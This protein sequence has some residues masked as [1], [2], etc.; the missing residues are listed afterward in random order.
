[1]SVDRYGEEAGGTYPY[2]SWGVVTLQ[3]A[4]PVCP[5]GTL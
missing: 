2:P 5:H 3:M 1:M 4:L